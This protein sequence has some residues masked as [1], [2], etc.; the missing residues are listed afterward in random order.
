M[1]GNGSFQQH[2][3]LQQLIS[4]QTNTN[5]MTTATNNNTN[6]S[7][8]SN[9]NPSSNTAMTINPA[10]FLLPPLSPLQSPSPLTP[11]FASMMTFPFA[12]S[13]SPLS[14]NTLPWQAALMHAQQ[15]Q[16][17]QQ[18]QQALQALLFVQAMQQQQQYAAVAAASSPYLQLQAMAQAGVG[19]GP[20]PYYNPFAGASAASPQPG[21]S[22][23]M[24]FHQ[25]LQLAQQ[26]SLLPLPGP[27]PPL[28]PSGL[29]LKVDPNAE[30]TVGSLGSGEKEGLGL[31]MNAVC[32]HHTYPQPMGAVIC[33]NS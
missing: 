10:A 11:S 25:Q 29:P 4:N 5:N 1:D 31:L 28:P 23:L 27:I 24:P 17:Q 15:Q 13:H 22:T 16:H 7:L 9:T 32:T 30:A 26:L 19:V 33:Y 18:Q 8:S 20:S 12:H 21:Q 6:S 3:Q 2:L 14:P